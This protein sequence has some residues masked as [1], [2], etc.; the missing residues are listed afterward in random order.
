MNRLDLNTQK[1]FSTKEGERYKT[2]FE[3]FR[4]RL[5][6]NVRKFLMDALDLNTQKVFCMI[7]KFSNKM[8][9]RGKNFFISKNSD[10]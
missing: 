6:S 7:L 8:G 3:K 10:F 2:N 9:I 4:F 1:L 5:L